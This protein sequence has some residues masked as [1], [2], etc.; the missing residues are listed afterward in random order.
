M[1]Y[2]ELCNF[3]K[4]LN[5]GQLDQDVTVQTPD[6]EYHFIRRGQV[7]DANDVLDQDHP[8]LVSQ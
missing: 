6:D 2:R 7:A 1:T 5:E 4:T 8:F 3:I